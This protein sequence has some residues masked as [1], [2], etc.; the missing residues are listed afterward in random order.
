MRPVDL[1]LARHLIPDFFFLKFALTLTG[2][3]ESCD[4]DVNHM[5]GMVSHALIK[6]RSSPD[7]GN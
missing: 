6:T 2:V 1:K 5:K 4:A 7:T 3:V